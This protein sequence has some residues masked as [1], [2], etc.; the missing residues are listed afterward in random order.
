MKDD[1]ENKSNGSS[2]FIEEWEAKVKSMSRKEIE[3]SILLELKLIQ[4]D[5]RLI[6]ED[7]RP[8]NGCKTEN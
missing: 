4:S 6:L 5:L 3:E 1:A 7:S 2:E 8:K